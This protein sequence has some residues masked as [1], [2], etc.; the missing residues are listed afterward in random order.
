MQEQPP[1]SLC[2]GQAYDEA[3]N[4]TRRRSG[5]DLMQQLDLEKI[6]LIQ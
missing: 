3:A 1:T 2:Q 6:I 4:M 5:A